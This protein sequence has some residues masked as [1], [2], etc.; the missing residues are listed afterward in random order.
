MGTAIGGYAPD[1]ELPGIDNS[2]H[3]LARY[4]QKFRA[5]G[6]VF[7]CNHCPYVQLY[8]ARLKEVQAEFTTQGFTLIGINPNDAEQFP[9]DSFDNMKTFGEKH[10]LNFPYLR[11][12][13]QDVAHSFGATKTPQV[14]LINQAGI[15]CY[16]G[17]IDDNPDRPEA[18]N[19]AYLRAAIAQILRGTPVTPASTEPIGCSIKWRT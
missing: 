19:H 14:F 10:T 18:V 9:A 12:V 6:V 16:S 1:F 5:V 2:V 3:H 4:L 7:M 15:L 8:L 11:D 17:Q 13:T